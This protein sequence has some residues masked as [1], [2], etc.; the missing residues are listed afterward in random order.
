MNYI[1]TGNLDQGPPKLNVRQSQYVCSLA[2]IA[3]VVYRLFQNGLAKGRI[4]TLGN[5]PACSPGK[6]EQVSNAL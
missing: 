3:L 2:I 4:G 5:L 6:F 1:Q